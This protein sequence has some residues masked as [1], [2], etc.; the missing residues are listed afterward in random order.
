MAKTTETY[1]DLERAALL[2]LAMR[3][4]TDPDAPEEHVRVARERL[5]RPHH[6]EIPMLVAQLSL[7]Q[8]AALR[9]ALRTL[10]PEPKPTPPDVALVE[11]SH[12][13]VTGDRVTGDPKP[14]R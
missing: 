9:S 6:E 2:D 7:T 1:E 4:I 14:Q 3:T 8:I 11:S 13:D 5:L 12:H 10:A